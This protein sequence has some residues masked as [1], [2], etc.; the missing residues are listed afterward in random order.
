MI[1]FNLEEVRANKPF[2]VFFEQLGWLDGRLRHVTVLEDKT[3][4]IKVG[5][6][7]L[8]THDSEVFKLPNERLRMKE[9]T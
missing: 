2:E 3:Y 6:A 8:D 5:F 9:E 1:P 4:E 7:S